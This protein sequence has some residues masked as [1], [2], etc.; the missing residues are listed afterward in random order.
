V[1]LVAALMGLILSLPL[2]VIG[3]L[4][5][6]LEGGRPILYHQE[7]V[8]EK[9]KTFTLYKLRTMKPDAEKESG[10]V[11]AATSRDPRVTRVGRFLRAGRIDELPQLIN[12]LKGEM[13]FVG[14]R[15]ERPVFV[16]QLRA[17]IPYYN[18][19]HSVKP[20]MTGWAQI[21]FGYGSSTEEAEMKLRYDLY[22]IKHM[23]PILDFMILVD[24]AKVIVFG[25]GAR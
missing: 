24:T 1:D 19:R 25:K 13:S 12:V 9:G 10:P 18:E 20:G 11:W 5:I 21:K 6:W 8:G 17:L 16:E 14:P 4:A 7:R 22:Y 23:H 2:M 3:A 15:P